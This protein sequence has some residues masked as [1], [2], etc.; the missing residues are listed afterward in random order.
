[1]LPKTGRVIGKFTLF[2]IDENNH[3][4]EI[5]YVLNRQFWRKGYG[6]EVV[7]AML[8]CC[9]DHYGMHRVEADIDPDNAA[10]LAL[11]KKFGF[12]REGLFRQRWKQ[13]EEWRDS[14]MMALLSIEWRLAR[15]R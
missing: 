12:R 2:H 7:A 14:V 3:R 6:S 8:E 5:G 9:F 1:M 4:A 15:L 10:S 13:G 11:L